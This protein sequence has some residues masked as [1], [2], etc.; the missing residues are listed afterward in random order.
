[1]F[2]RTMVHAMP[3][4]EQHVMDFYRVSCRILNNQSHNNPSLCFIQFSQFTSFFLLQLCTVLYAFGVCFCRSRPPE[5]LQSQVILE[6]IFMHPPNQPDSCKLPLVCP[7]ICVRPRCV[8]SMFAFCVPLHNGELWHTYW[9]KEIWAF[10]RPDSVVMQKNHFQ[11]VFIAGCAANLSGRQLR[12][13][14]WW[15]SLVI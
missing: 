1:M 10:T 2:Y 6:M 5:W 12:L 14:R 8:S 3:S 11:I 7:L 15:G 9:A 4:H 13:C